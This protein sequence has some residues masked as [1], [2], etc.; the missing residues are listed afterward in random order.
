MQMEPRMRHLA[1]G[2]DRRDVVDDRCGNVRHDER[3]VHAAGEEA[4]RGEEHAVAAEDGA[5]YPQGARADGKQVA[6]R[7]QDERALEGRRDCAPQAELVRA[8]PDDHHTEREVGDGPRHKE[9]DEQEIVRH[10]LVEELVAAEEAWTAEPVDGVGEGVED[11]VDAQRAHA[12]KDRLSVR[13]PV[14]VRRRHR[15]ERR[16]SVRFRRRPRAAVAPHPPASSIG[17]AAPEDDG[18]RQVVRCILEYVR[19]PRRRRVEGHV[20]QGRRVIGGG[21]EGEREV[22]EDQ[23]RAAHHRRGR[24]LGEDAGGEREVGVGRRREVRQP[25]DDARLVAAAVH[26]L[27]ALVPLEGPRVLSQREGEAHDDERDG[28]AQHR[29]KSRARMRGVVP[30]TRAPLQERQSAAHGR[31]REPHVR[32]LEAEGCVRIIDQRRERIV[33]PDGERHELCD[34]CACHQ[35]VRQLGARQPEARQRARHFERRAARLNGRLATDRYAPVRVRLR[36][37]DDWSTA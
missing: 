26:L 21:Q 15:S 22:E 35:P 6:H 23:Q 14:K 34:R 30:R 17:D 33:P 7:V 11:Q 4:E 1:E 5:E 31:E 36:L 8:Q 2:V 29:R 24:R 16:R 19:R 27:L 18:G 20:R 13:A 9:T 12:R 3:R 10:H 37:P 28:R 32:A 25:F